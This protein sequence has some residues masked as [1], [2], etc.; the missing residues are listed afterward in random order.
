MNFGK[1]VF[2]SFQ[3][4]AR[5]VSLHRKKHILSTFFLNSMIPLLEESVVNRCAICTSNLECNG[6]P[7]DEIYREEQNDECQVWYV[8]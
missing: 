8:S 3:K 7:G 2:T 6:R 5:R 4:I 1:V